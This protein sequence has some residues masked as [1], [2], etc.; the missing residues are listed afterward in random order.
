MADEVVGENRPARPGR[1]LRFEVLRAVLPH[2][3]D[4]GRGEHR[5]VL[6]GHV[7]DRR[8]DL[9]AVADLA[10]HPREGWRG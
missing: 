10:A 6:E 2:Q 8:E 3:L 9:D 5:Q 4:A 7:L 1:R